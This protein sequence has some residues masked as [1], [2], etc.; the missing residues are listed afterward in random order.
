MLGVGTSLGS[1][2]GVSMLAELGTMAG[3][4]GQNGKTVDLCETGHE[5]KDELWG[6]S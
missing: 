1:W 2:W 6:F 5:T 4:G 3:E